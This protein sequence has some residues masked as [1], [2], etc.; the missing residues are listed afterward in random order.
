VELFEQIR[1]EYEHGTETI[2]GLAKR[3]GIHGL[4]IHGLRTRQ[5]ISENPQGRISFRRMLAASVQPEGRL[6][7]SLHFFLPAVAFLMSGAAVLASASVSNPSTAEYLRPIAWAA[8]KVMLTASAMAWA[9]ANPRPGLSS[10]STSSVGIERP[11]A[12]LPAPQQFPS[13]PR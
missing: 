9:M 2:Q 13:D 10:P 6:V 5:K 3:L 12:P 7:I 1:R 11:R 4:R 8:K